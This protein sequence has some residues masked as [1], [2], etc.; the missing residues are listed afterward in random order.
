MKKPIVFSVVLLTAVLAALP[1]FCQEAGVSPKSDPPAK[2]SLPWQE[3]KDILH[4]DDREIIIS[5]ETYE[6]L[7]KQTGVQTKPAHRIKD[8]NVILSRKAFESL[9]GQMKPPQDMNENPPYEYLITKAFYHGRMQQESTQFEADFKVHVLKEGYVRIPVLPV[10]MA[11]EDVRVNQNQALVVTLGGYHALLLKK[12]GVYD[13]GIRFSVPS[14]LEKGPHRIDLQIQNTPITL[15][16]LEIPLKEIDVEIPQ[17]RHLISRMRGDG[18]RIYGVISS[19][20]QISIRWRK[21]LAV[22][23][24]APSKLYAEFQHLISIE[25]DALKTSSDLLINILHSEIESVS[26]LIPENV[27]ILAVSGEGVGEWQERSVRNQRILQ[28]PFTYS[29]KGSTTI[30]I[31]SE[32]PFSDGLSATTFQGFRLPDA[33]RETG[34][35]G[36]EL[37]TSAEVIVTD[38]ENIEKIP[39]QKLPQR[40][41]DKSKKP[42]IL[43]FK[44]LRHPYHIVLGIEKHE[45]IAVPVATIESANTVTLFTED[46]KIVHRL[47]YQIRNSA[48]QFLELDIPAD[49][50]VW[51]VFVGN[52][53]VESSMNRRGRLLIPLIR[54]QSVNN[55]LN[56]FPVEVILCVADK[57]FQGAKKIHVQLPQ[58]DLLISQMIW[59]VYLPNGYEYLHFQSTLEKEEI[60]RGI[61]VFSRSR[62]N[63]NDGVRKQLFSRSLSEESEMP[64]EA[65]QQ[66]YEGKEYSSKFRNVPMDEEQMKSQV[67]NELRFSDR[68]DDLAQQEQT[69]TGSGAAV[70]GI[71]PIQVRIPTGGQVYRFAKTII[72][73][74]DALEIRVLYFRQWMTRTVRWFVALLVLFAV[75]CV[76]GP[77]RRL[78]SWL[79]KAG[80]LLHEIYLKLKPNMQTVLRSRLLPFVLFG[81]GIL[82]LPRFP[83]MSGFLIF[84]AVISVIDHLFRY[85]DNKR[86]K[87]KK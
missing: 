49:A 45:K 72:K 85:F 11:V 78:L 14:S 50:D 87:K 64:E 16:E 35:V 75:Y 29:K 24:K 13:V 52:E 44:Y 33:V 15:L 6:K 61:H 74:E 71:L 80:L 12:P 37:N 5:L 53:P 48:K 76:R 32:I 82:A 84:L 18:T 26:M 62:R 28:I 83:L 1:C 57:P 2:L 40:L 21:K 31:V 65:L 39:I 23:E 56:T 25:D 67:Q 34:F 58:V 68:L 4:L 42:M 47:V 55:R 46:G 86:G 79:K 69:V 3:F 59:S 20:S 60:I 81:L 38:S 54:S 41:Y 36:V 17:A 8:G 9:V 10:N 43:G 77:F 66:V 73:P 70:T 19:G 51:S 63:Y 7:L 27:N 22:T 30:T